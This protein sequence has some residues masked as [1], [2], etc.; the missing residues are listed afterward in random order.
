MLEPLYWP[1]VFTFLLLIALCSCIHTLLSNSERNKCQD[2][3]E[4]E[5]E[6]GND[7]LEQPVHGATEDISTTNDIDVYGELL[8]FTVSATA[9]FTPGYDE[10]SMSFIG[11]LMYNSTL[12]LIKH[13][14]ILVSPAPYF[15]KANIGII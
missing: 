10:G 7:K 13:I 6:G 2:S 3:G 9:S 1:P 14:C 12:I 4:D 11:E 8:H 5:R 15:T